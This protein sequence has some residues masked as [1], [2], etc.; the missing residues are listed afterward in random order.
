SVITYISS[1]NYPFIE[2]CQIKYHHILPKLFIL[3]PF[4]NFLIEGNTVTIVFVYY[5][6]TNEQGA[7]PAAVSS[8]FYHLTNFLCRQK[9]YAWCRPLPTLTIFQI[10]NFFLRKSGLLLIKDINIKIRYL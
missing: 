1:I 3:I 4:Y 5:A 10:Y 6:F 9:F 7:S 2:L 8:E